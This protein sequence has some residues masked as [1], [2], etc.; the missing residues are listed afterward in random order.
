MLGQKHRPYLWILRPHATMM[1]SFSFEHFPGGHFAGLG[2]S[3]S[4]AWASE[5]PFHLSVLACLLVSSHSWQSQAH[6]GMPS[7]RSYI[8]LSNICEMQL[9]H[10][11]REG[12][13]SLYNPCKTISRG[14]PGNCIS[15]PPDPSICTPA[16]GETDSQP[17]LHILT[18]Q[19]DI[20][21]VWPP[22]ESRWNYYP[23]LYI[24]FTSVVGLTIK[25]N[26]WNSNT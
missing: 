7:W 25:I 24:F 9:P 26:K 3:S 12:K 22:Q 6:M 8:Q 13:W 14:R 1:D 19:V 23:F 21:D 17:L 15:L 2:D 4:A 5:S 18:G 11:Y 16:A 20:P 10:Q